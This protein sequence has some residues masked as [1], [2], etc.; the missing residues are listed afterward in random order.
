MP[1]RREHILIFVM[2]RAMDHRQPVGLRGTGGQ[3]R[4]NFMFSGFNCVPVHRA[5]IWATGLKA[6]MS[7]SPA[8]T[9]S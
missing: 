3:L 2:I 5:A 4:Y 7:E 9:L 1:E 8:T 6:S